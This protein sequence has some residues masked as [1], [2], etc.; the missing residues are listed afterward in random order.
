MVTR[1]STPSP[2]WSK[3]L[4]V[5]DSS[6][7]V[8]APAA[9]TSG[10][11]ADQ[12]ARTVA[13]ATAGTNRAPSRN[14]ASTWSAGTSRSSGS[15]T[16]HELVPTTERPRC[17]STMSPSPARCRRLTTSPQRRPRSA[18][19]TPDTS[20]KG[21]STAPLARAVAKK[22]SGS[23]IAS[24]VASGTQT[25]AFSVGARPGSSRSAWSGESSLVG[26]EQAAQAARKPA[27]PSASSSVRATNRP[28][29]S[30]NEPGAMRRRMRFSWMHS[31]A[32][33]GSPT[34]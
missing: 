21:R 18:S 23:R 15:S 12:A 27:R 1:P 29:F 3:H 30:S 11:A 2:A 6:L 31:V 13:V 8:A 9:P 19:S 34:A 16:T 28:P 5:R 26:I 4:K 17:G 7:P 25:A 20:V 14:I 22:R 10:R 24:M 32:D 33:S